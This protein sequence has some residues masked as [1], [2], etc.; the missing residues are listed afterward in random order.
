MIAAALMSGIGYL[1]MASSH[2]WV[3]AAPA[4]VLVGFAIGGGS[5]VAVSLRQRLTP[6]HLMGRV[7]SAWRG[8]VW[9]ATPVG[10]LAAGALA[11]VGGLTMPLVLAG[12]LQVAVGV[13]LARPLL[14]SVDDH[15]VS[16]DSADLLPTPRPEAPGDQPA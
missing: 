3:L 16:S 11:T 5:V 1:I 9:G 4:F 8:I 2:S 12:I 10:V 14:R 15:A 13:V 7:G 6:E